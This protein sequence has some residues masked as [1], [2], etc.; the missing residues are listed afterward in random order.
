V[1]ARALARTGN[2]NGALA[3]LAGDRLEDRFLRL[4]VLLD[5]DRIDAARKLGG[6]IVGPMRLEQGSHGGPWLSHYWGPLSLEDDYVQTIHWLGEAFPVKRDVIAHEFGTNST[7]ERRSRSG[8]GWSVV[9]ALS[10]V[11]PVRERLLDAL[12]KRSESPEAKR[13]A[14]E[15][16]TAES[17]RRSLAEQYAKLGRYDD[18]ARALVPLIVGKNRGAASMHHAV[19]WSVY[20]HRGE[21]D[22]LAAR[23]PD[24]TVTAH[25][26]VVA[27]TAR[28]WNHART[29]GAAWPDDAAVIDGLVKLGP[30][31]LPLV[32]P[33][34]GP[35]TIS[36]EDRRV[37]VEIIRRTASEQDTPPLIA[38]LSLLASASNRHHPLPEQN[39]ND[40]LSAEAIEDTLKAKTKQEGP[41]EQ[42]RSARARHWEKWWAGEAA[43]IVGASDARP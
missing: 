18:A 29:D 40:E 28:R 5:A 2:V 39:R 14:A 4:R 10:D 16:W 21:L 30:A 35:N 33:K 7:Y 41:K 32:V 6:E 27:P 19:A 17:L 36:G 20:R 13:A 15:G 37:W 8:R 24:T 23:D 11:V 22:A 42:D 26:L 34:L 38:T 31:V 9:T 1:Y 43:R 12:E 25:R 3:L